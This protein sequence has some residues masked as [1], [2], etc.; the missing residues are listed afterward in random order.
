MSEQ[1]EP[2]SSSPGA[3]FYQVAQIPERKRATLVWRNGASPWKGWTKGLSPVS[4]IC[5]HVLGG[6][7]DV[8]GVAVRWKKG[9]TGS[10]WMCRLL[11][12]LANR[13]TP[14]S[15]DIW[16]DSLVMQQVG[17]SPDKT[18]NSAEIQH[19]RVNDFNPKLKANSR[20]NERHIPGTSSDHPDGFIKGHVKN[21]SRTPATSA[22]IETLQRRFELRRRNKNAQLSSRFHVVILCLISFQN[23][24]ICSGIKRPYSTDDKRLLL[25]F[26]KFTL[27]TPIISLLLFDTTVSSSLKLWPKN[28]NLQPSLDGGQRRNGTENRNQI[29]N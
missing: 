16:R 3:R 6:E 19:A 2:H 17:L 23:Q 4:E 27:K 22:L 7:N 26:D 29:R 15:K 18:V 14:A 8:T 24:F 11:S 1:N 9:L 10:L 12:S 20:P 25:L 28:F 5:R 13:N 21:G